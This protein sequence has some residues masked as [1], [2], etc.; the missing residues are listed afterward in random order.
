MS[1]GPRCAR[2][3]AFS[4]RFQ[5]T[6][7]RTGYAGGLLLSER[8][9]P[10][11]SGPGLY[12]PGSTATRLGPLSARASCLARLPLHALPGLWGRAAA[13]AERPARPFGCLRAWALRGRSP[14]HA[15]STDLAGSIR[16][17]RIRFWPRA[18]LTVG[19]IRP[20]AVMRTSVSDVCASGPSPAFPMV[21]LF[22]IYQSRA[23]EGLQSI[24]IA[25]QDAK[26]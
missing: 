24:Q 22:T 3:N 17:P 26:P 15:S 2:A 1:C 11:A 20:I 19:S 21:V 12:A 13:P 16:C 18:T 5:R 4:V 8:I 25:H 23:F 14:A 9:C 10:S 6:A 7:L